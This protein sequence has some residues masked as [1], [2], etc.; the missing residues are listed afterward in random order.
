MEQFD[1]ES[2]TARS[3]ALDLSGIDFSRVP[4][5]PLAP[6]AVRSLHYMQDIESHTIVYLRQLLAT[7][8]IDDPEVATFLSCWVYEESFHGRALDRFLAAA[9][10][11]L[12]RPK[13][14]SKAGVGIW[15]EE[16]A[17]ALLSRAWSDFAAVHMTWGAVNELTTLAGYRRLAALANHPVLSELLAR[18][19][20]DESRHFSFYFKQAERRLGV[21]AAARV[22]RFLVEHFWAPV[23]SGVQPRHET[24]FL[25]GYLFSGPEGRAAVQ[26]IDDTI[27]RLPGF[28]EV[29][30]LGAWLERE[31][32]FDGARRRTEGCPGAL[33]SEGSSLGRGSAEEVRGAPSA[34]SAGPSAGIFR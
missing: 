19:V 28:Q 25:A 13:P 14:R 33:P 12:S 27:R 20:R 6:E 3:R 30:L 32:P 2:Y 16:R 17:A 26:K 21:P 24:L 29:A 7:R 8:V 31:L 5:Y 34:A 10:H 15:L 18:I 4:E 11:R 22:T 1:L 23:G 9:G